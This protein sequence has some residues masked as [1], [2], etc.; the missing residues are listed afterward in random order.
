MLL[1]PGGRFRR[2]LPLLPPREAPN[3]GC[4]AET[5][6]SFFWSTLHPLILVVVLLR[7]LT[8]ASGRLQDADGEVKMCWAECRGEEE[9][10]GCKLWLSV[11]QPPATMVSD[12][13][14]GKCSRENSGIKAEDGIMGRAV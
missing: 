1:P 9:D 4:A 5:A 13:A 8:E 2:S 7:E 12:L 10:D 6:P 14:A 11:H 3:L